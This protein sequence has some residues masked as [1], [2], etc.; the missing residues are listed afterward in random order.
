[1]RLAILERI[2]QVLKFSGDFLRLALSLGFTGLGGVL[3]LQASVMQFL[4]GLATLFFQLGQQFL[5]IRQ[6]L[7]AG[8]FQMFEQ[9]TRKLLEQV[10]RRTDCFLLG[11]HGLPPG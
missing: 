10:Q 3:Q 6:R 7:G 9:A 8:I 2:E 4:L 5:G 11:R 1:M